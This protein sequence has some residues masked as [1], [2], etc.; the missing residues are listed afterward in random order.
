VDLLSSGPRRPRRAAGLRRRLT[1]LGRWLAPVGRRLAPYWRRRGVRAGIGVLVAIVVLALLRFT[2]DVSRP[3]PA[4]RPAAAP[5]TPLPPAETFDR[6]P[7]RTPI[8]APAQTG[9][10]LSGPL[11]AM[12]APTAVTARQ[13]AGLVL[14]RYCPDLSRFSIELKPDT[15]GRNADYHHLFV[16]VTDVLFTDSGPALQ[17][18]LDWEG[19]NYRWLGPLTLLRGC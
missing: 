8:P 14:G 17:L 3:V 19:R 2:A 11:P 13:A 15:D 12:A 9:D 5:E 16:L 7:G 4:P 1:P 18:S 6:L 10:L